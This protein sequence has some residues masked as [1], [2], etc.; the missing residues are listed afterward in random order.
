[1]TNVRTLP[2]GEGSEELQDTLDQLAREGARRMTAV[3][4]EVTLLHCGACS[5]LT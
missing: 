4:D 2:V 5:G 3:K 1:M